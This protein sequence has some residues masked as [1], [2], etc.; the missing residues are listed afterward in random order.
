MALTVTPK[1]TTNSKAKKATAT[2]GSAAPA[3]PAAQGTQAADIPAQ[4]QVATAAPSTPEKADA[5]AKAAT[6]SATTDVTGSLSD[7]LHFLASLGDPSKLDKTTL[8]GKNGGQP[9]VYQTSTIIGYQFKCD[10]DL[11]VP[12]V[13]LG[14]DA[15]SNSMSYTGDPSA[16][17]HVPAGT[18]FNLSRFET[19]MLMSRDEF[20]AK[21]RGGELKVYM[22]YNFGGKKDGNG[23]VVKTSAATAV[24]VA[25]LRSDV[26]GKSIKDFPII[27]VM[28][29]TKSVAGN[30]NVIHRTLNPGFEKFEV[31]CKAAVRSTGSGSSAAADANQRNQNA[32]TFL[33]IVAKARK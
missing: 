12:N 30:K 25:A 13:P 21:A 28:K 2:A 19:A 24:P 18:V 26:P 3:A 9:R 10:V 5:A 15:K 22:S 20:N 29:I 6:G 1:G 32:A 23:N 7:K 31:F 33:D 11:E 16:T 8:P 27:D 17:V 14:D 4:E